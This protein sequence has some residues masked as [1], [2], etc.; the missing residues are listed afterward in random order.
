MGGWVRFI[1]IFKLNV[2]RFKISV[3]QGINS[4][5]ILDMGEVDSYI[6]VKQMRG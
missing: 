1:V 6:I 2:K 3:Y 4:T 5:L